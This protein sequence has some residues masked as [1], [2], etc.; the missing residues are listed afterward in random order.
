MRSVAPRAVVRGV[1]GGRF[2]GY[3]CSGKSE[4]KYLTGPGMGMCEVMVESSLHAP[5]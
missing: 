4:K 5:N 1:G 3:R 2:A